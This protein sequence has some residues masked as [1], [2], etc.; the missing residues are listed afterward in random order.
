MYILT[1]FR[2]NAAT[3][4]A[5]RVYFEPGVSACDKRVDYRQYSISSKL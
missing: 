3:S 4:A 5:Q 2:A 1:L